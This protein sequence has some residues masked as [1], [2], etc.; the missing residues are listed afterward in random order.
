MKKTFSLKAE[1]RNVKIHL[2]EPL[3]RRIVV[4]RQR[5]N[6]SPSHANK[7]IKLQLIKSA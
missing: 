5:R 1:E 3:K 6:R 7:L 4:A 2:A